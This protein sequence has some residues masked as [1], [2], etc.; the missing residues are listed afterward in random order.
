MLEGAFCISADN[1]AP[2]TFGTSVAVG[3]AVVVAGIIALIVGFLAGILVFYCI[4]NHQSQS[5]KL[6][7][8]SHQHPHTVS[9]SSNSQQ[10]TGPE[11]AE[12][13]AKKIELRENIAYV[14]VQRRE[15][16]PNVPVQH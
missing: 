13:P 9:S 5:T 1:V 2:A 6:K 11:Y 15:L 12:V 4:S 8:P 10:Q 14:H 7:S 3:I 16:T